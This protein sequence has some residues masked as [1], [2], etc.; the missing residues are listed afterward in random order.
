MYTKKVCLPGLCEIQISPVVLHFL[1]SPEQGGAEGAGLPPS[2]S[3]E[4]PL[5]EAALGGSKAGPGP[6][7]LHWPAAAG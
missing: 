6:S 1:D 3:L 7:G 2:H 4:L 5:E